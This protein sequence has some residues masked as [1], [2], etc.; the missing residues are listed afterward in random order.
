MK[1]R[2]E[3]QHKL[4]ENRQANT[5]SFG[6]NVTVFDTGNREQD[7]VNKTWDCYGSH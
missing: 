1:A 5:H 3:K 4:Q 2:F 6:H 7:Y